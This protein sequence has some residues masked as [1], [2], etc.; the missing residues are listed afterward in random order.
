MLR[1][2]H[3]GETEQVYL[4]LL[5]FT[6]PDLATP[7]RY[8]NNNE[9]VVSR[10]NSFVAH[11]F[12]ITLADE[13]DDQPPEIQLAVDN[14]DREP[15]ATLRALSTPP[16]ISIEVV[17]FSTPDTLEIGP[18]ETRL[19]DMQYDTFVVRGTLTFEPVLSEPYPGYIFEPRLFPAAF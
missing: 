13:R 2:I 19:R 9:S 1:A 6:H 16:T 17:L 11:P 18:I 5:T 4:W 12:D 14:V 7:L 3:A 15:L 8:T 10:G